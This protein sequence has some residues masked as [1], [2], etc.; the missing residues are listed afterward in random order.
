MTARPFDAIGA[1]FD[2][3]WAHYDAGRLE[4]DFFLDTDVVIIGTG[5]GGGT[6]ARA[7]AE[8]GFDVVL[9]EEGPLRTSRDFRLEE[10]SAYP[11]LYQEAA[12]RKTADKAISI[13]QGRAVGGSTLVNW[14]TSLHTPE[15]T[16]AH[17]RTVYGW[18]FADAKTMAPWFEGAEQRHSI[19]P[20]AV[21][22]NENNAALARGLNALGGHPK[23]VPRNVKGCW[24]LG[25]CGMGCPVNAKQSALV[26][27]L[28]SALDK[29]ARLISSA[30]VER[31]SFSGDRVDAVE[32]CAI[33]PQG[34]PQRNRQIRIRA[35]H[36]VLAAGAIGSPAV[37]LRSAAPDPHGRLG[38]R[39][40]LHPVV[41]SAAIMPDAV[42]A[43]AGAPQTIYSDD[44]LWPDDSGA[45]FKLEVPP[46]Y[47]MIAALV[48]RGHGEAHQ[49]MMGKLSHSQITLALFRDGF[50]EECVGGMVGLDRHGD[51]VLDYRL[52][53]YLLES[54]RRGYLAMAEL[55]F[56]AGALEVIPV[57]SD[58]SAYRSWREARTAI[59][60]LPMAA[61]RAKVV[62]A[63]VMG[64]CA[65][66][67]DAKYGVADLDGSH[68]QV[69]NLTICDGSIFPT[70]IG[71]NPQLS[72]YAFASRIASGLAA[73]LKRTK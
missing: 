37:L 36:V 42:D 31:L 61:L 34:Q 44:Y 58:A 17:W 71:A 6:A 22:P 57:H 43:Y 12:A 55:Q 2:S 19:E 63:H 26:A 73:R 50:H 33:D 66:S 68:H 40:F 62:S 35:R 48:Q 7:L 49:R 29:G 47:P 4:K 25:Y 72:V 14:T 32:C 15:K 53:P 67:A 65:L 64:G 20:W 69:E 54:M 56:A 13:L 41:L 46:V 11:E 1:A 51:P 8:A 10:R 23:V 21:A 70:S 30:R 9:I 24:N 52:T 18:P 27:L 16:L 39:T 28:P 45:G 3:R 59:A 38:K 5:A 60:A